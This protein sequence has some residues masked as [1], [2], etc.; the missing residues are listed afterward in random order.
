MFYTYWQNNSGGNFVEDD[1]RG[2][3][4]TVI[5]EADTAEEANERAEQ[6]GLYFD[7]DGD[8][9]CCGARWDAAWEYE[10][11][12]LQPEVYGDDVSSGKLPPP[13]G[14]WKPMKW[15]KVAAYIHYKDGRI[16]TVDW[17]F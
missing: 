4:L 10:E 9:E 1:E 5:I 2:I 15:T 13:T 11:G 12:D 17:G 16:V 14:G 7:G 3:T 8:C 6:I